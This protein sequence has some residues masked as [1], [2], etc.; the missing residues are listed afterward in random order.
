MLETTRLSWLAIE[1]RH[2]AALA[3]VAR[4]GSF[5]AAADSLG[6]VQSAVS[7]QIAQLEK[8]IGAPLLVRGPGSSPDS[9]TETGE[10]LLHHFERI[11]ARFRAAH[12][13]LEALRE[14]RAGY[15][16][17][18]AYEL[19]AASLMPRAILALR[20]R[21]PGVEVHLDD[22]CDVDELPAR[23]ES[24]ELDVAFGELPLPDGPFEGRELARDP[25]VLLAPKEWPVA[26]R[27]KPPTLAQLSSMSLI[28]LRAGMAGRVD[29]HLRAVGVEPRYVFESASQATV[30][31]LVAAG[32]GAAVVPSLSVDRCHPWTVALPLEPDLLGPRVVA[33][34]W[35]RDRRLRPAADAFVEIAA[36]SCLEEMTRDRSYTLAAR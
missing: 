30:Q 23:V 19:L 3:A 8:T 35:H 9:L 2:L 4:E 36:L 33:L 14:G 32:I 27:G 29:D 18:G 5:R 17:V 21:F 1:R 16:R 13:D 12:R 22:T 20:R 24:G 34:Y 26:D 10:L 25:Y 6:Y 7:Q 15:L 31:S 28:R 11:L